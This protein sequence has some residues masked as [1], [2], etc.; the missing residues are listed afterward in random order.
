MSGHKRATIS[1]SL[2]EYQRLLDVEVQQRSQTFIPTPPP[3]EVIQQTRAVVEDNLQWMADRQSSFDAVIAGHSDEIRRVETAANHALAAQ[4]SR[5]MAQMDQLAGTLWENTGQLLQQVQIQYQSQLN[6]LQERFFQEMAAVERHMAAGSAREETKQAIAGQ[7]LQA[8]SEL[9]WLIDQEYNHHFFLPGVI[10]WLSSQLRLAEQNLVL[11]LSEASI[12]SAQQAYLGLT[13]ARVQLEQAE[14]E[15]LILR[16][17]ANEAVQAVYA[18]MSQKRAVQAIDLDGSP[19]EPLLDVDYWSQ[20]AWQ[21]L[22]DEFLQSIQPLQSADQPPEGEYMLDLIH[23]YLPGVRA[24]L[25]EMCFNARVQALNSQLRVNIADIVVQALSVQGFSLSDCAYEQQDWR[26]PF[27]ARLTGLDQSTV[28]VQVVPSG[29]Q[30]GENELHIYS[31]D[32]ALRSQRELSQRWEEIEGELVFSGLSV[33][34]TQVVGAR[35]RGS[36]KQAK[37][38]RAAARQR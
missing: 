19:I 35:H 33:G 30:V 17:S 27:Q 14:T 16:Q 37:T 13:N 21:D 9:L 6:G 26:N 28:T 2:E 8:A 3:V 11:G 15:W 4:Q 24:R 34:E 29:S 38:E 22:A 25:G 36:H 12:A 32:Q 18:E 23:N 10:E 5:L 1:V 7:W 20:G 31:N